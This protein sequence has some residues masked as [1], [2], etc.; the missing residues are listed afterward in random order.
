[1][2]AGMDSTDTGRAH[3]EELLELAR[4]EKTGTH[5]ADN[6]TKTD[7]TTKKSGK[8]RSRRADVTKATEATSRPPQAKN[9]PS[10]PN[11]KQ[12]NAKARATTEVA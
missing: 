8:R 5:L 2:L 12:G 6:T 1:M 10:R 7:N 11:T 3:A 9:S 4:H